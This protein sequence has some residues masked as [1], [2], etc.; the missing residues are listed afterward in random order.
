MEKVLEFLK[1]FGKNILKVLK[2]LILLIWEVLLRIVFAFRDL[3]VGIWNGIKGLIKLVKKFHK[4]FVESNIWTKLSHFVMGAGNFANKQFIKGSLFLAIQII[5]IL[6]MISSPKVN[7]TP[8]GAEAIPNFFTLGEEVGMPVSRENAMLIDNLEEINMNVVVNSTTNET[9]LVSSKLIDLESD[10]ED[11]LEDAKAKL[12]LM[13]RSVNLV[14]A[15][16]ELGEDSN[17]L[18]INPNDGKVYKK[19]LYKNVVYDNR[20]G[21]GDLYG[22][23][24]VNPGETVLTTSGSTV[25]I[26]NVPRKLNTSNDVTQNELVNSITLSENDADKFI[27]V[28]AFC[29]SDEFFE[30]KDF[31]TYYIIVEH[32][33]RKAEI[34]F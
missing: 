8:L 21:T 7:D 30:E 9:K 28:G 27:T 22:Y 6:F 16:N 26:V 20:Y 18:I 12:A 2:K 5:F 23:T 1:D 13:V 31:Y 17:Q 14:E 10:N 15:M 11:D 25:F 19:N 4:R 3:G 33:N 24:T 32:T 34:I 29:N